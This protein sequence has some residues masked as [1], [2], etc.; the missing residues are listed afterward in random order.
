MWQSM[1]T[2]P[3][4]GTPVDLWCRSPGLASGSYGRVPDCWFSAG[5]WWRNDELHG[6]DMCRSE[7]HNATHWMFRPR[8]PHHYD[9][10]P[11]DPHHG[12]KIWNEHGP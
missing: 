7:V 12:G 6:D 1:E 9:N 11:T 10:A 3:Q 5:K 2:A 4:D 8:S